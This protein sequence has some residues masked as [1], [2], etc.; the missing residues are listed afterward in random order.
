M[1]SLAVDQFVMNVEP[2]YGMES[3][4]SCLHL[5]LYGV[6][7][8]SGLP[9][10]HLEGMD[11]AGHSTFMPWHSLDQRRTVSAGALCI[12]PVRLEAQCCFLLLWHHCVSVCFCVDYLVCLLQ[13]CALDIG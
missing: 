10:G 13:L 7:L 5:V 2:E 9:I 6:G 1:T 4:L 11:M 8:V 12:S 3:L